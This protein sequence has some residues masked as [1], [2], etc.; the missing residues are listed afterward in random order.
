VHVLNALN[1]TTLPLIEQFA[2]VLESTVNVS[3][4]ADVED[5]DGV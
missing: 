1:V 5:A 3:P 2:D 4:R